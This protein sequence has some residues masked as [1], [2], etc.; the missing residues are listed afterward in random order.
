VVRRLLERDADSD[1]S[2]LYLRASWQLQ[3]RHHCSV[4]KT[5]E[6]RKRLNQLR[7]L[8]SKY[9]N[10]KHIN[11]QTILAADAIMAE[12]PWVVERLNVTIRMFPTETRTPTVSYTA[13]AFIAVVIIY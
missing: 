6:V 2:V 12:G 4:T 8:K 9:I 7:L 5:K 10:C 13:T 3:S 1:N 11:L